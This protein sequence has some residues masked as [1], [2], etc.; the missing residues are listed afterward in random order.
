MKSNDDYFESRWRGLLGGSWL[1]Y[2]VEL[3]RR[4]SRSKERALISSFGLTW[5]QAKLIDVLSRELA[6]TQGQLAERLHCDEGGL[7]RLLS[8]LV[9]SGWLTKHLNNSDRR[10]SHVLLTQRGADTVDDIRIALKE[11]DERF[12]AI[13]SDEERK[14]L[15]VLLGR[16]LKN[17]QVLLKESRAPSF[18]SP[19]SRR[20]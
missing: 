1:D 13:L 17:G 18:T 15:S 8:R 16:L 20:S 4:V 5:P 9:T 6:L 10:S 12:F 7:S 19:K 11:S 3:D 14:H 2:L